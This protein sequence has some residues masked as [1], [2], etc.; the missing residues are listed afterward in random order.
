MVTQI[1]TKVDNQILTQSANV[2]L[3][4]SVPKEVK[5]ARV[6][7]IIALLLDV[8]ST[9]LFAFTPEEVSLADALQDIVLGSI[10]GFLIY[11]AYYKRL[12]WARVLSTIFISV[13]I[14]SYVI[15]F[16][17][18]TFLGQSYYH[19]P[20]YI[21]IT[22]VPVTTFYVISIFL[23]HSKPSNY[24]FRNSDSSVVLVNG[25]PTSKVWKKQIPILNKSF[26]II[27]SI[28]VFGLDL[29]IVIGLPSLMFFWIMMLVVFVIFVLFYALESFLK[30][31]YSDTWSDVDNKFFAIILFRNIIFILCF[32]PYIQILGMLGL[33]VY[34]IPF[35]IMY[36]V[37]LVKRAD[38][39]NVKS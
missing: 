30:S 20:T 39:V 13:S 32:I 14:L 26:L 36:I 12:N 24:W 38:V 21:L 10:L 3:L 34:A 33:F 17:N 5:W 25:K 23:G 9:L 31:K 15:F 28:L 6:L 4:E 37:F 2:D 27:S 35:M 16:F 1:E 7:L 11:F 19:I 8:S 22:S 29:L 18:M